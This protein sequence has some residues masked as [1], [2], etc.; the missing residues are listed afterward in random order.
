M[1]KNKSTFIDAAAF[2]L[3]ATDYSPTFFKVQGNISGKGT[4]AELLKQNSL[5]S[6]MYY[7]ESTSE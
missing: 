6:Q 4:H 3:G 1:K 7:K 2:A 5:Y